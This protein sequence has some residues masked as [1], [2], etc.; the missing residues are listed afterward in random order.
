MYITPESCSEA[1]AANVDVSGAMFLVADQGQR[2]MRLLHPSNPN[3]QKMWSEP[4]KMIKWSHLVPWKT[5]FVL[6]PPNQSFPVCDGLPWVSCLNSPGMKSWRCLSSIAT[7]RSHGSRMQQAVGN[8][9]KKNVIW[10]DLRVCDLQFQH[11]SA[12]FSMFWIYL[13]YFEYWHPEPSQSQSD[14]AFFTHQPRSFLSKLCLT[15]AWAWKNGN[16]ANMAID[17]LLI[18]MRP[19]KSFLLA[20]ECVEEAFFG[21]FWANLT[22][23]WLGGSS[24]D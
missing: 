15:S 24:N 14:T 7:F 12:C 2:A 23:S 17:V 8:I 1:L 4:I 22:L 5:A 20:F 13:D 18:G 10:C 16:F 6:L 19:W 9:W 21:S 11:V 3:S